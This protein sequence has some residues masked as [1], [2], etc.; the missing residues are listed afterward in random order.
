[1]H[2]ETGKVH[3]LVVKRPL[4]W[5]KLKVFDHVEGNRS[6]GEY[7]L[8][9]EGLKE[10]LT[11]SIGGE[12]VV[13]AKVP[14]NARTARLVVKKGDMV[15]DTFNLAIGSLAPHDIVEGVQARL[16]RLGFDC[17]EVDGEM[18]PRTE[19]AIMLFRQR[20]SIEEDDL[21][22]TATANKLKE[23]AGC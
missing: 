12:G 13:E 17:G 2:L 3:R 11:G 1:M 7:V 14:W 23:L 8:T 6:Q 21:P 5:L 16:N 19:R 22:G 18:G 15:L 20:F 4:V 9:V 10:P